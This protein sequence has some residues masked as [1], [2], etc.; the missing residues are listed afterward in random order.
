MHSEITVSLPDTYKPYIN[1]NITATTTTITTNSNTTTYNNN[2]YMNTNS[3]IDN[4]N[5]N[6]IMLNNLHRQKQIEQ[7]I[8]TLHFQSGS[9]LHNNNNNNNPISAYVSNY[10][11]ELEHYPNVWFQQ[12]KYLRASKYQPNLWTTL[13]VENCYEVKPAPDL[14]SPEEIQQYERNLFND[15]NNKRFSRQIKRKSVNYR[16]KFPGLKHQWFRNKRNSIKSPK[17]FTWLTRK[18]RVN[19]SLFRSIRSIDERRI[20]VN[21]EFHQHGNVQARIHYVMQLHKELTEQYRL[22]LEIRINP[23]FPPLYIGVIQNVCDYWPANVPQSK[24]S[25]KRPRFYQKNTMCFCNMPPGI[26]RQRVKLNFNNILHEL[27]LPKFLVSFLF[28]DKKLDL[29]ITIKLIMENKHLVGCMK[30]KLPLQ[31]ISA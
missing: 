7:S 1:T 5:V 4:S 15:N 11:N 14:L 18:P 16:R 26:Y 6:T 20:S 2:Y 19:Y 12:R 25:L 10:A 28:S 31:F 9:Y 27:E 17:R 30:V 3:I 22:I 13:D 24:C 21:Q 23:E 29:H 8:E